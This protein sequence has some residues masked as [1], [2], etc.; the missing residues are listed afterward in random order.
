MFIVRPKYCEVIRCLHD[1]AANLETNT[2]T[3]AQLSHK[4]TLD[5]VESNS[6]MI[7]VK[8]ASKGNTKY[9]KRKII[10]S[11]HDTR[12]HISLRHRC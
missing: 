12:L 1:R 6:K 9:W 7:D 2:D 11:T 8:K 10:N 3:N 4:N 5:F